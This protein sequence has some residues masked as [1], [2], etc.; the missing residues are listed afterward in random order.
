MFP[1]SLTCLPSE[2]GVGLLPLNTG[3]WWGLASAPDEVGAG[4]SQVLERTQLPG[5]VVLEAPPQIPARRE[6]KATGAVLSATRRQGPS[7]PA[8]AS[9]NSSTQARHS[10]ADTPGRGDQVIHQTVPEPQMCEKPL[11]VFV[12]RCFGRQQR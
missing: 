4:G 12:L 11:A 5:L 8:A 1:N 2:G 10:Q 9:S 6:G 7:R 3:G